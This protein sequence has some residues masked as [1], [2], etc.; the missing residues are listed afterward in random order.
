MI[1][2]THAGLIRYAVLHAEGRSLDEWHTVGV[3][4]ASA[5]AFTGALA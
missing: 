5:T 4:T 3:D 2:I 1:A